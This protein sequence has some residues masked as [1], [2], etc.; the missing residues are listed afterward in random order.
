MENYHEVCRQALA[1]STTYD[2]ERIQRKLVEWI[3]CEKKD[4]CVSENGLIDWKGKVTSDH[5]VEFISVRSKDS[6]GKLKS[7]SPSEK[8]ASAIV[9]WY[10]HKLKILV[11]EMFRIQYQK[12]KKGMKNI[13]ANALYNGEK[14]SHA[15]ESITYAQYKDLTTVAVGSEVYDAHLFLLLAWNLFTRCGSTSG[16]RFTKIKWDNDHIEFTIN[17]HKGDSTGEKGCIFKSV[18]PNPLDPVV[19]PINALGI[20]LLSR[21]KFHPNE[22]IFECANTACTINNWL[23]SLTDSDGNGT[24]HLQD[25]GNVSLYCTRKGML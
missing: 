4:E 12:F 15:S 6:N 19:C 16:L 10:Q 13:E 9:H 22:A 1:K 5:L 11:P 21:Q 7:L 18:Y 23:K 14:K 20:N 8:D 25:K 3:Q 2:Y 24:Q 17:K